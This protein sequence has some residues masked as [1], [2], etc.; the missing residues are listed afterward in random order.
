MWRSEWVWEVESDEVSKKIANYRRAYGLPFCKCW[1]SQSGKWQW[2]RNK[3]IEVTQRTKMKNERRKKKMWKINGFGEC[4]RLRHSH[5]M[6]GYFQSDY[7]DM[8]SSIAYCWTL[9]NCE[10]WAVSTYNIFTK[11]NVNFEC[12]QSEAKKEKNQCHNDKLMSTNPYSNNG[13]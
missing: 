9:S 6:L 7:M 4:V 1:L 2:I 10:L 12:W 5:N 8:I 3:S 11:W 13:N